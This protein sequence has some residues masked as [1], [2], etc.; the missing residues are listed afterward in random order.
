[1][2]TV[3]VAVPPPATMIWAALPVEQRH[4]WVRT[5]LNGPMA[6]AGHWIVWSTIEPSWTVIVAAAAGAALHE[7]AKPSMYQRRLAPGDGA[8]ALGFES[9]AVGVVPLVVAV[10]EAAFM[11]LLAS[12][13]GPFHNEG[14][15]AGLAGH[16]PA[17]EEPATEKRRDERYGV[18]VKPRNTTVP[19]TPAPSAGKLRSQLSPCPT[20]SGRT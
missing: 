16:V 12:M 2:V 8:A 17:A 5:T 3:N 10:F 14:E 15:L 19:M 13:R 6:V 4:G 20:S 18:L 7:T 11:L 9:E 1:M